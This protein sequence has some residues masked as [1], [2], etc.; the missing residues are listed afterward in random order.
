MGSHEHDNVLVLI[1]YLIA[2]VASYTVLDLTGRISRTHGRSRWIWLLFGAFA[3]GMGIWSMHFV[4]MMA[5]SFQTPV[6]YDLGIVLISVGIAML[7]SLL[8]L[9]VVSRPKVPL[10][11]LL[12]GA[13]LFALGIVLMHYSGMYSM[14][15]QI[16]YDPLYVV[17][18]ILI[19]FA[20]S[21]SALC[22]SAYFLQS[23]ASGI[24]LKK[25][26]S[27][28]IM[29][30]AIA[31]MHYVGMLG[32]EIRT[33][34]VPVRLFPSLNII[35]DQKRLAYIISAGS[36][37]TLILS[38]VG[39]YISRL[40]A[41]KESERLVNEKWYKSLYEHNQDGIISVDLEGRIIGINPA[42][43]RIGGIDEQDFL[44]QKIGALLP[45][46]AEEERKRIRLMFAAAFA[47]GEE[48]K[49]ET[50]LYIGE[51][52][53]IEIAVLI[54][55]VIV[56]EQVTGNYII[57][58]DIT[59]DK[60][61]KLKNQ[62]M[63]FHDELT[64]LPNRRMLNHMLSKTIDT[65]LH[66]QKKFIVMIIDL[67]RFKIINDSVGHIYGDLT[68]QEM[69]RRLKNELKNEETILA[70]MGGDEFAVLLPEYISEAHMKELAERM[71]RVIE[72]PY[73]VMDSEF[74][75][76]GSIGIAVYPE[77]GEDALHLLKNADIAMYEVKKN[78]KNGYLVF[79]DA[80]K[81][82][83][84]ESMNLE[85]D[86]RKALER[87]EFELYF[88]PQIRADQG[89]MVGVEALVR[90]N[91]PTRGLLAPGTF[92]SVAEET[93]MIAELGYWVLHEACK[94]MKQWHEAGGPL[95]SIGVNLSS[96]QFHQPNLVEQIQEILQ[97]TGLSPE[98]LELEITESMMMDAMASI[99]ILNQLTELGIRIS[100][101]DFGTGYSSFNYLKMFP[102]HKVKI[103]RSFVEHIAVNPNDRAIVST[104][105]AMARQLN[106]G[107]IAEGIETKAQLDI[108]IEQDC[109][110]V[111][112]YYYSKPLPADEVEQLFFVPQ[113]LRESR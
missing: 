79:S 43:I 85:N 104:M 92:I 35:F 30:A 62:H 106:M 57:M 47:R 13:C 67:D 51:Q 34:V 68:L 78:G 53:R 49:S 88:Q 55:P 61:M 2:V 96:R 33:G 8:A 11:Q 99:D 16:H 42:A 3:M 63:A 87:E 50:T 48:M 29:G 17:L 80:L 37:L 6:S 91:H 95:I 60:R 94:Q 107:V 19:A 32:V 75:V 21:I 12:G 10:L 5:M 103:D 83:L 84:Q 74:H 54:A 64:G 52:E 90:W 25:A 110:D 73:V 44:F 56:D 59:E 27:A 26:G 46:I 58:R 45:L 1:S 101:D 24:V 36:L 69:G 70:R 66:E 81:A 41:H 98:Y 108:I 71:T 38:L 20:A 97:D 112:G 23:G 28:L 9:L 76:T 93:G 105:I 102:I 109:K 22:L 77:H 15:V 31:G 18:S 82:Q 86:L 89:S 39:V 14:Q 113:R 72:V 65:H 7:A 111:Q 4:G 40:F 100:L